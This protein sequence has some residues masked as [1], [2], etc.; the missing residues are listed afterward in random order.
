VEFKEAKRSDVRIKMA[1][2]GPAGSGK[3]LSGLT[4]ASGLVSDISTVGVAQTEPGRAQCYLEKVGKFK[5]L[6]IEPPFTPGKF[7]E[8]IEL[9]EES[10]LKCLI[11]DSLSDEWAGIGGALDMHHAASEVVR[12][13]FVAWKKITPQHEALF[14]KILSS[15]IHI[16]C[17]IKKKSDYIMEEVERNGKK[18]VQPKRVGVKDIAREG[19]EYRWMLQFDLD[20]DG[21]L[22]STSKD[23]TS[24]FQGREPFLITKQTGTELRN[25]CLNKGE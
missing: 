18:V 11:I 25:W 17:T 12:N 2:S 7:V 24:L 1:L 19:T 5:V 22:A 8:I 20:Q 13:S 14:N 6:E 9:A 15:P 4:I 10:G 16:I 3:T 21:N 23:N